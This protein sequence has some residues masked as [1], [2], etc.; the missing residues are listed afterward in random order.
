MTEIEQPPSQ[1]EKIR[2]EST[3]TEFLIECEIRGKE[4]HQRNRETEYA[5]LLKDQA[6]ER[7]RQRD[8]SRA[9]FEKLC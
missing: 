4:I 8:K 1:M 6:V 7:S 2:L 5:Q 9:V 3:N